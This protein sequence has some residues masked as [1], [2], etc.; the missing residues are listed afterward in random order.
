MLI[1]FGIKIKKGLGVRKMKI[2]YKLVVEK[3]GNVEE[4]PFENF[5][6]MLERVKVL[7]AEVSAP[8]ETA[9]DAGNEEQVQE[10]KKCETCGQPLP[11]A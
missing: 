3:D 9:P 2:S 11:Q 4:Q 10:P 8:V 7:E 6:E 5:E 1:A